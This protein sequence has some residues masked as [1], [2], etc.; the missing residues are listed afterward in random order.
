[1]IS[2]GF[3]DQ[4]AS[5]APPVRLWVAGGLVM[6]VLDGEGWRVR[7]ESAADVGD[8]FVPDRLGDAAALVVG[9]GATSV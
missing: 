9:V 2:S 5:C 6:V 4:M 7:I 1:M 3:G 8:R